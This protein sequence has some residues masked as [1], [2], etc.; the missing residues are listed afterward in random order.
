MPG[1]RAADGRTPSSSFVTPRL[2]FPAL[3]EQVLWASAFR[4]SFFMLYSRLC[5]CF[6]ERNQ[7]YIGFIILGFIKV[8]FKI[9]S[10]TIFCYHL[11]IANY[12][13]L[14]KQCEK[15]EMKERERRRLTKWIITE[16]MMSFQKQLD[17]STLYRRITMQ[18]LYTKVIVNT[19]Q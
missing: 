7:S 6:S 19:Y 1:A 17:E 5:S 8:M 9:Y 16:S 13:S 4:C 10:V 18:K 14:Q 3:L 11:Y 15:I 2:P 12:Q